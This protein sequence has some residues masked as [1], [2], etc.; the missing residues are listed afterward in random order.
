M[1]NPIRLKRRAAGG[2]AGA[3]AS[4]L[5]AEPA[6]N[7][8]DDTLYIGKGDDG[9]GNATSIIPIAGKGAFADLSTNQT[10]GG[11]K[12]FSSTIVGSVNGNAGT[13]TKLATARN[14]AIT[15]DIAWNVNFD[16]SGDV[17]AAGTLATVNSNIGAYT[18]LTVNAKGLVTAATAATL[19][20]LGTT[21]AD[22]SMNGY[23][24]TNV[25]DPVSAQ[26]AATKAYVDSV[27]Q[28]LNPK[29]SVRAATTA[30]ITLSGAQTIDGV[31][32]VAGNRVLVKN[33]TLPRQN[34][35][36]VAAAGAWARATDANA[37]GEL[38]SAFTFVE[39]G[40][41]NKDTGWVSQ[42]DSGGVLDTNDIVWVQ[43]SAAGSYTAGDGI[44]ITGGVISAKLDG[45]T[46]TK[47]ANGLRLSATYIGQN[48]IT[49]L[50]TI[51][52]GVW[53]GTAIA[54]GYGGLGLTA[55]ITGL[56]KGNG[57][58]YSAAVAGTDYVG[59]STVIDGG[60]F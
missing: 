39:E 23:K 7:E 52:T 27:A 11:V 24:I 50:G 37:W 15:G 29:A 34:G 41:V 1:A 2:A 32:V 22:F 20:D 57:S 43:F 53:Q 55:A 18:K 49:T 44:D 17:T 35:I 3:P 13:A 40:T 21:A 6:Y 33:Q 8:Q 38:V 30:T 46:L 47:S 5:N 28:G 25:A 9:G 58:S 31:S 36:Y 45:T 60:T 48:T 19:A 42:A 51:A 59:M 12:T 14:I 54:V 10:I 26:D 56:L 16:G 4:L